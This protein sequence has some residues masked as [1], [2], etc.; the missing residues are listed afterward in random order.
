MMEKPEWPLK[1]FVTLDASTHATSQELF[2]YLRKQLDPSKSKRF[3]AL[4]FVNE[5]KKTGYRSPFS[6]FP[7]PFDMS[8]V[9]E[10]V[11]YT[12]P[13]VL[14]GFSVLEW[15]RHRGI[16]L[17]NSQVLRAMNRRSTLDQDL[18]SLLVRRCLEDQIMSSQQDGTTPRINHIWTMIRHEHS[19][20]LMHAARMG[21]VERSLHA[22]G[23]QTHILEHQIQLSDQQKRLFSELI[24]SVDRFQQIFK[25]KM[26]PNELMAWDSSSL[27][28]FMRWKRHNR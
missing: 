21:F 7:V 1:D 12:K 6:G 22:T 4:A 3:L 20:F 14:A 10:G 13:R 8:Q 15:D 25:A 27:I 11:C 19:R 2:S 18:L 5:E 26:K 16:L 9:E 23:D 24:V 17:L 28:D